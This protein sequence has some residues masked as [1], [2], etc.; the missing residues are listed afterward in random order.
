MRKLHRDG[1]ELASL[2]VANAAS[3]ADPSGV[4]ERAILVYLQVANERLVATTYLEKLL[5]VCGRA[6]YLTLDEQAAIQAVQQR[7]EAMA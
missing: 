2:T 6:G 7:I 4:T 5:R 3:L 1:V